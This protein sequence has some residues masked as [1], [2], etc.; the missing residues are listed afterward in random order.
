MIQ[1]IKTCGQIYVPPV[2]GSKGYACTFLEDHPSER[3]SWFALKE[4]YDSMALAQ[5]DDETPQEVQVFL[6]AISEGRADAYLEAILAGAHARKRALRG[7]RL[8]YGVI[9]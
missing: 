3:H 2:A 1:I 7:T 8:P 9:R 5:E 6:D 4:T